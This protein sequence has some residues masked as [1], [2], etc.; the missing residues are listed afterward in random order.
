MF[1]SLGLKITIQANL[2]SVDFLDITLDL[3]TGKYRPYRKPNDRPLYVH[4]KSNHPPII[5]QNLP[6]SISRRLTDI[7]ST[8]M[9]SE[10]AG[11]MR[12]SSSWRN[13]RVGKKAKE[14]TP[15]YYL[16]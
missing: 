4:H 11:T 10:T 12:P 5:I 15:E 6:S 8:T 16:V 2:K 7:S 9:R 1:N 3:R 14:A 13:G